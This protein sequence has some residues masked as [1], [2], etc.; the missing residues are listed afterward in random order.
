[1]SDLNLVKRWTTLLIALLLIS[2]W[3]MAEEEKGKSTDPEVEI[4]KSRSFAVQGTPK[5]QP[6]F[7]HFDYVNPNAP[8]GG[9]LRLSSVGT[10]DN[11]NRYA[12]RGN[13]VVRS[14]ELYDTLMVP[15]LDEIDVHY[16]LIAESLEY[17]ENF[18]WVIFHIDPRAQDHSG[19]A[20][21]AE[22]VAFSFNKF[23]TQG[24]PQFRSYF[25]NV[26][27]AEVLDKQRVKFHLKEPNRD[28]IASL[29]SLTVFPKHY[30]EERSLEDPLS[31]PPVA[32]GPYKI[33]SYKMGQSVTYERV[34]DYWAK[35]IPSRKGT[36]NFD[37]IRYDYYRDTTVSLEAFKAGEYDFR[38]EGVAKHWAE[39]YDIDA[40][41]RGDIVK[42]E[43]AHSEP[44]A[45]KAFV[46][47]TQHELF[48][49]RRVRQALNYALDF[50][51][52]N[53]N[54]FYNQYERTVSYFQNTPYM[55]KGKPSERE[56]DILTPFKESIPEEVFGE[57]WRPNVT[58]GSG[59]IRTALRKAMA[60]LKEAGWELKDGKM[61]HGETGKPFSFELI[62][63]SPTTERYALPF[64]RNLERLGIE[65]NL[66]QLDSS[67]FLSRMRD[68][69]YAM[70]DRGFQASPY[71]SSTLPIVWHSDYMDS[72]YNQ[73]AVNDPVVD[74]LME[75]IVEHQQDPEALLAHGRAFDRLALWNFYVIPHWHSGE[76][77]VAY[78][79]QFS[80][81]EQRP[82]YDLGLETWWYDAEK[83]KSVE[84]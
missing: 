31:E 82:K 71:P 26:E 72:S 48:K 61:V 1:M 67:Q 18:A 13:P 68:Q 27:K 14:D 62:Y 84:R 4:I 34:K 20:I 36:M 19:N 47:N 76:Y 74:A 57:V 32:T 46:F 24:V 54:L 53:Q 29:I 60:L 45:M 38:Q 6:D 51:W 43:L 37:T 30:W 81:P 65:V 64:K 55:A 33:A 63:Y 28:D 2:P 79:N 39:D 21:T 70:I 75:A 52:L 8:K 42:E 73:A 77:R 22:D 25:K 78:W 59:N 83:A 40:V 12:M 9:E 49:D 11:F 44:Q 58:D 56:K 7:K 17:P 50:Q 5:Y 23:M 10:F 41:K 66:R 35:D 3:S 69:D 16:P 80:R 15:S